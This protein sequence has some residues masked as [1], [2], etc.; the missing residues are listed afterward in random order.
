MASPQLLAKHRFL[1]FVDDVYED[2][3]LWYPR[4]RLIEAGAQ[5][6]VAGP[7]QGRSYAGKHGYPCVADAGPA[8]HKLQQRAVVQ[9]DSRT[10]QPLAQEIRAP[11]RHIAD[12]LAQP[13]GREGR[14][15][16]HM[17][18]NSARAAGVGT[19]RLL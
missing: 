5:V 4:L 12:G 2:L 13:S 1:M 11:M 14:L 8:T 17:L 6:V 15:S 19:A 18:V 16:H 3:E 7:E 9:V 10:P